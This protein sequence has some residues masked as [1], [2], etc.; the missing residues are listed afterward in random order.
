[1]MQVKIKIPSSD[2]TAPTKKKVLNI[3]LILQVQSEW[4]WATCATMI[5]HY[6]GN[7]G[8]KKCDFA[9]WLFKQTKCCTDPNSPDCNINCQWSDVKKVYS[10]WNIKSK[11]SNK[12]V[13]FSKIM[14]EINAG[15]PVEV[16]Y[17]WNSGGGHVVI[18]I[19]YNA[20]IG[21]RDYIY[22]NDP[23][24]GHGW[25]LYNNILNADGKGTWS[26]TWTEI[27]K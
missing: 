18:V 11:Q 3:P 12:S 23:I 24:R 26:Y 25:Y 21:A 1:M 20:S 19:G 8:I 9:N 5:L 10:H 14:F 4:C 13:L 2:N 15:R 27:Q 6:Y 16:G 22:L 7:S 17:V